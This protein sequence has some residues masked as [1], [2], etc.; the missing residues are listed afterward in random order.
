MSESA[1]LY[2]SPFVWLRNKFLAGL[3]VVI[4]LVVSD[5]DDQLLPFRYCVVTPPVP[6]VNR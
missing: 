1:P 4:P 2:R 3:A 6:R 5:V